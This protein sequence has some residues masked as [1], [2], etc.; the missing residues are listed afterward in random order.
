M[1][2]FWSFMGWE[3]I[4]HL[5]E[6]F[7]NPRR[8]MIRAATVAAV[9]VGVLYF[10][11]AFVLIGAGIFHQDTGKNAPLVEMAQRLYGSAGRIFTGVLAA[12]ICLGTMNAYMAGLS[13]LGYS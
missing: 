9:V 4:A 1:L 7:R 10:A 11:V 3:A 2:I 13:R 5:A 8:D 6:E 12:V